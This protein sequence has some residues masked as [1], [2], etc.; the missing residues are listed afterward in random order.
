MEMGFEPKQPKFSR[1]LTKITKWKYFDQFWYIKLTF[2]AKP[3]YYRTRRS[4]KIL[5]IF[6]HNPISH[7]IA[8]EVG[9]VAWPVAMAVEWLHCWSFCLL[10]FCYVFSH[11]KSER[12]FLTFHISFWLSALESSLD[13]PWGKM[14]PLF[15]RTHDHPPWQ[16]ENV[17]SRS[18]RISST[19]LRMIQLPIFRTILVVASVFG[20]KRLAT[21]YMPTIYQ[22][23]HLA[24]WKM[25][26]WRMQ[27]ILLGLTTLAPSA[28]VTRPRGRR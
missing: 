16:F 6:A 17:K 20:K 14:V 26:G 7:E 5:S 23:I 27:A 3:K 9:R 8:R 11:S 21:G 15:R 4:I 10:A 25:R 13:L 2:F 19:A 24:L 22:G 1:D 18:M 28:R 12:I